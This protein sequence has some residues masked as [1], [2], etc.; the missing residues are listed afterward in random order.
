MYE[1][2]PLYRKVNTKA[3]GVHHNFGGKAKWDRNTKESR[4][5]GGANGSMGRREQRGLDY[6]PLYKFLLSR[7]GRDWDETHSE[8]LSRL[9]NQGAKEAIFGM[10]A[11]NETHE[12]AIVRMGESSYYS[13]LLVDDE[14]ILQ[15]V[16]PELTVADLYPS[17]P[18]CTHT[19]NGEPYTNKFEEDKTT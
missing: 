7:V 5:K 2:K 4:K 18:C 3:R 9:D 12:E 19:F 10:V 15:R 13:G 16:D 11:Q 6:T 17:C 8:A 14:N 1:K